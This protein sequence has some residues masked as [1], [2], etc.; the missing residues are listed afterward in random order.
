[1]S[2]RM[3]RFIAPALIFCFCAAILSSRP[4]FAQ[5][6]QQGEKLV[7]SAAVGSAQQGT[8]V[9]VSADGNTLL[10]GGPSDSGGIGA[11]W[12]WTRA[13]GVWTQ[14]A[15]LVGTGA[16]GLSQQ[17]MSVAI[18]ADGNTAIV[19]GNGDNASIGA[20]WI[21]TRTNGIWAQQGTKLIGTGA[22]G[23]SQQG[24]S[25]SLSA[26]GNTA[27]VGGSADNASI[28]AAWV[29]TRTSA[30]WTQ[31]GPKLV[32][33]GAVGASEQGTGVAVSPEGDT[34]I[35]G[36]PG[37]STNVGAAWMW[38]RGGGV[39]TQQGAKLVAS[40]RSGAA[41]QG[42]AVSL[43]SHGL[44]AIVGGPADSSNAGAAWIWVRGTIDLVW[45]Q[46]GPKLVGS[47]AAGVAGQGVAVSLSLNGHA[48]L[49]GGSLDDGNLGA[50]WLWTRN[51]TIWSQQGPKLVGTGTVIAALQGRS[52]SLSADANTAIVGGPRDN[53]EAGAAWVFVASAP[54]ITTHPTSQT[55][56]P[57]STATFTAAATGNPTPMVQWQVSTDGGTS[58]S[59]ISGATST[60][61][62]FV[63]AASDHGKQFRAVFTNSAGSATTNA[64]TLTIVG[65]G[66]AIVTHPTNQ[67]VAPGTTATFTASATGSPTPSVQWQVSVNGG[68]S[69]SDISGATSTT[70]SFT[71]T[72]ADNGK[73][74]RAVFT[75]TGGTATS[76]AA[77]LTVT[78][79]RMTV[80]RTSLRFGAVTTGTAFT[81]QT[82][83]Q[84]I[85]L[86]QIGSGG[87]TWSAA[88]T[89]PWLV[90]SPTSGSGPAV[91]T[92]SVQ[93]VPGLSES[94]T[95]R[96]NLTLTGAGGTVGPINVTLTT[97][98]STAAASLPFGN[99]DTPA[100]DATVLSGSVAVTGWTLDNIGV[101]RVELWRDL[102]AGETTT[103]FASTPT[104]PRNGKVF[105][106]NAA[107]VDGARPDIEG[108][109]P[110]M[111]VN[112]RG[113]WGYL[114]LTWGLWNQ[115]NGTYR[116]HAFAFDQENNVATIGTKQIIVNNNAATKPFGSIDTPPVGG[117]ASGANFG[118]A[119]T[120]KVNGVATCKIQSNGVQVSIDSGPLQPVVYGDARAD[121]A[122]AF[123]GYSNS[124]A[125]GGHYIF[126][127][128]TLSNGVHTIGWL[129]TDDCGRA[130]GIGSRFF[131]VTNGTG[132]LAGLTPGAAM[133][134]QTE[135]Q[136]PITVARGH[137]ELPEI[138]TGEWGSRTVEIKQGERIEM[139]LP[140]GF[141]S[142]VQLVTGGQHRELPVGATWDA[143]SGIF[144]WEPAAGF[145]GRY[146]LVFSNGSERISV[147]VVVKP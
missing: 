66:P 42:A 81:S 120:P 38:Q 30:V 5:L 7:G 47:G 76:N 103:P 50:A 75:N 46:Q 96:I 48:A 127:W 101:Q 25:V 138:V 36:G 12:V 139:R 8:S 108:L 33:T 113:G 123:P 90:V 94:Q 86:G 116:L 65:S 97:V 105:I 119:L 106:A 133:V 13:G 124:A 83:A 14:Q 15:K 132:L 98:P 64:A 122:A 125:A 37:D 6:A 131:N 62:S 59:D 130:D 110:S 92:I 109:Y 49:V 43:S 80:D 26:D 27:I 99:F 10:V 67:T 135:S 53:S 3:P 69:F 129:V 77:T 1:M 79:P 56:A 74:F 85:R 18:S 91:L 23:A 136:E 87:V 19:G 22:V 63:A 142:A 115:G 88:S 32:G 84:T 117:D 17:G 11:V 121:I 35:V 61:Y 58:F 146:R 9:A 39:W 112:Y 68:A 144:S 73:Q 145:L 31:Q 118:W 72:A 114:M 60:T 20:A 78:L 126:D 16:I 40:D 107:F 28:G 57:G 102:Q 45:T 141:D 4:A 44:T 100:G 29:W 70:Y 71:A 93:F 137:G 82:P 95:G 111:P 104:D 2:L 41:R 24:I 54:V 128:S 140:R 51:G 134:A 21:W 89:V 52:V 34:A 143:A 147:R 55:V